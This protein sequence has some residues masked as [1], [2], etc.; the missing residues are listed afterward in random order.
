MEAK[1]YVLWL[2]IAALGCA[3]RIEPCT[4]RFK[5]VYIYIY[6]YIGCTLY[7]SL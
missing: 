2:P 5:H 6:V 7:A 1:G 3:G 4:P